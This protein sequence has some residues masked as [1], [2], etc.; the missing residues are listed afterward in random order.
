[1]AFKLV[2]ERLLA[3]LFA[4]ADPPWLRKGGYA[5]E[6]RYCPRARTTRDLDLTIAMA[7][8]APGRAADPTVTS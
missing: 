6:L 7:D 3:Q 1:M 5:T 4:A 2:M 8:P